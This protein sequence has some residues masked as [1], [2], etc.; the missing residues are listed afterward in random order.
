MAVV[1][2]VLEL[3]LSEFLTDDRQRARKSS[4]RLGVTN[5]LTVANMFDST[6]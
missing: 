4:A 3:E 5:E 1:I 2:L 6:P